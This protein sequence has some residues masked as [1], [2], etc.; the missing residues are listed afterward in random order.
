MEL[1]NKVVVITGGAGGLGLAMAQ[2]LGSQGAKL[3]LIDINQDALA[4]AAGLLA[5]QGL[6][7]ETFPLDITEEASVEQVFERIAQ[8][9]GGPHVLINNAGLLRDGMLVKVKEGAVQS[10]MSLAQFQS[11]IDVNLT[12]SFLCG[13]EAAA[14]M[15]L[16]GQGGVIINISSLARSGNIGQT[17]YAASKAAVVAMTTGWAR[18]LARHNIRTAAIAPGVIATE[19]VESMKPEALARLEGMIPAGRVGKPDEIARTVAF[20]VNNDYING[21]VLEIDGGLRF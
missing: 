17:N 21:R 19:M 15:A 6:K 7:A 10:K 2:H 4:R 14:Q 3:V 12:G 13:R 1:D 11:V 20:I 9:I 18:E 8:E 5:E 16:H